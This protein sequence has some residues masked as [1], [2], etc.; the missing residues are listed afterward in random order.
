M[1]PYPS[2]YEI[3][4]IWK[5]AESPDTMKEFDARLARNVHVKVMGSDHPFSRD[6]KGAD[7]WRQEGRAK[8]AS[9]LDLSQGLSVE[10]KVIGGGDVPWAAVEEKTVGKAKSGKF[11][12]IF[13]RL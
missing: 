8:M 2:S 9:I 4:D 13:H 11:T 12:L 10:V 7:V 6:Y 1:G 5:C 3:E